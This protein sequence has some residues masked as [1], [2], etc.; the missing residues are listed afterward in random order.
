M[1]LHEVAIN[2]NAKKGSGA[3]FSWAAKE[4]GKLNGL[5][6]G[7]GSGMMN[8][9][10]SIV[11]PFAFGK[12]ISDAMHFEKSM[13]KV[14]SIFQGTKDEA[15]ELGKF[16]EELS[17][18]SGKSLTEVA[19]GTYQTI[20]SGFQNI[21]DIKEIMRVAQ[22]ASK[23][24]A[25]NLPEVIDALTTSLD[26]Y[27]EKSSQ[28]LYYADL[29]NVA[30]REGKTTFGELSANLGHVITIAPKVG[31]SF[32]E[33]MAATARMTKLG[34]M[35]STPEVMTQLANVMKEFISPS[36]KL[37]ELT[38]MWGYETASSAM[39][40]LGLVGVM[41]KLNAATGGNMDLMG[42]Y[43]PD[44]RALKGVLSLT[45]KGG[46]E[47]NRIMEVMGGATGTT[48]GMLGKFD[49]STS[50]ITKALNVFAVTGTK[51]GALI[52]PKIADEIN[53][54]GGT[55]GIIERIAAAGQ[56]FKVI[57]E[58]AKN[59]IDS[60]AYSYFKFMA[61][62]MKHANENYENSPILKL[63]RE[64]NKR[65]GDNIWTPGKYDQEKI[66]SYENI[67]E[68]Y[69][70]AQE[71]AA[72]RTKNE[73]RTY[74]DMAGAIAARPLQQRTKQQYADVAGKSAGQTISNIMTLAVQVVAKQAAAQMNNNMQTLDNAVLAAGY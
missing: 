60:L 42:Q 65:T 49:T 6:R 11:A 34:G 25:A 26:N 54:L 14:Y 33:L 43:I 48:M 44:I 37:Q 32:R 53:G 38:K 2:I 15:K 73:T 24:G 69:K 61:I 10:A 7:M 12:I 1:S 66:F 58:G 20:S 67:A 21:G 45:T 72:I 36:E 63:I 27:S 41:N 8:L 31:V 50:K 30:V 57:F 23:A 74:M 16:V 40:A 5:L 56:A 29:M 55:E 70:T 59:A 35:K 64:H 18:S 17:L 71:A 22:I 9:G 3:G 39:K 68:Q 46:E 19:E 4:A 51:I 28:A 52:L 62:Y 47:F 13:S